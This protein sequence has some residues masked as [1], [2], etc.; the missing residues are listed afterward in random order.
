MG[1]LESR[2]K[3]EVR[4]FIYIKENSLPNY[5]C[6]HVIKKFDKDLRKIDG[7]V[8]ENGQ[9]VN[10]TVKDTKDIHISST[11]GWEREDKTFFNALN[12]GL[13]EYNEYLKNLNDGCCKGFPNPRFTSSDTGYKV[14]KYQPNGHYHWH[15][16]WTMTDNPIGSRVFT[17]MWYLNTIEEKDDGY[18]EFADGTRIQPVCGRLI[19]FPATWTFI[20]RGYPPKVEKY[21][22]NGWIHKT[23]NQ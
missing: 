13:Q 18:T 22:C 17:F 1:L 9:R 20:H 21:L 19:F 15:H 23:I 16:D 2:P 6:N 10:K 14:Q 7:V 12:I 3:A 11:T 8:G 5:F 4:D